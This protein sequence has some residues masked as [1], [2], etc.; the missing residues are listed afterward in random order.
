MAYNI[1]AILAQLKE[2]YASG[3][4][5]EEEYRQKLLALKKIAEQQKKE[6]EQAAAAPEVSKPEEPAIEPEPEAPA[7]AEPATAPEPAEPEPSEPAT[8]PEP[9]DPKDRKKKVLLIAGGLVLI[10]IIIGI[11]AMV[12]GGISSDEDDIY[13]WPDQGIG[14]ILPEPEGQIV[15]LS[16]TEDVSLYAEVECSQKQFEAY[17]DD[18]TDSGYTNR[19]DYINADQ[20][21]FFYAEN[22][23]GYI[24]TVNFDG[25]NEQ[26]S[27]DLYKDIQ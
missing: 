6:Q 10:G 3:N 13:D 23:Q 7:P 9:A 22:G 17:V 25:M 15:Y 8:A 5:S 16:T 2:A 12:S 19:T 4:L 18:C 14:Q 27:V 21:G 20:Y 26:M 24:V 11:I 1:K